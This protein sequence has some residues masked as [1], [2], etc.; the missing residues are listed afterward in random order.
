MNGRA[1]P[2]RR[3]GHDAGAAR[4]PD[5]VT[6]H[7]S[8]VRSRPN[9][10]RPEATS[11]DPPLPV[12]AL[13]RD[14]DFG[15]TLDLTLDLTLDTG[16]A[17]VLDDGLDLGLGLVLDA[18]LDLVLDASSGLVLDVGADFG[19]T[20]RLGFGSEAGSALVVPSASR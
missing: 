10:A 20:F 8:R 13:L 12:V 18:G 9:S 1:R 3:C 16:V 14:L 5:P 15:F 7:R 19:A 11:P 2:R 6:G 4:R 17:L